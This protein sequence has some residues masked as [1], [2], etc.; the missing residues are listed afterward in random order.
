MLRLYYAVEIIKESRIINTNSIDN[1]KQ[2]IVDTDLAHPPK[3]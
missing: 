1:S 3:L 2:I